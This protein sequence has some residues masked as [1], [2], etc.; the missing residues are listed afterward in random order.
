MESS[1]A[2]NAAYIQVIQKM[3]SECSHFSKLLSPGELVYVAG[4]MAVISSTCCNK[5]KVHS[6]PVH[7]Y[8]INSYTQRE[9]LKDI[10]MFPPFGI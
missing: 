10:W 9:K 8:T 5:L 6:I 3:H 7:F 4:N 1:V 2:S